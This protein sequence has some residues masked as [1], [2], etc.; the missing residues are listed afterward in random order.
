MSAV[1]SSTPN[2]DSSSH[3]SVEDTISCTST[4]QC[5]SGCNGYELVPYQPSLVL[6]VF[7]EAERSFEFAG[8]VWTIHQ[9]W[10][11]VGLAAVVWEAVRVLVSNCNVCFQCCVYLHITK[12]FSLL[13]FA[14][15]LSSGKGK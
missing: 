2:T 6:P 15:Q 9:H 3:N 12:G 4:E 14:G 13:C 11:D 1:E 7:H 10:N 8:K 5:R